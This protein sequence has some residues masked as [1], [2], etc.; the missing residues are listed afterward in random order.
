M[1]N[2]P[3]GGSREDRCEVRADRP[4]A[5]WQLIYQRL[6]SIGELDRL[7]GEGTKNWNASAHCGSRGVIR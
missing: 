1:L 4:C 7:N 6:K 3:C 5:A 2:G